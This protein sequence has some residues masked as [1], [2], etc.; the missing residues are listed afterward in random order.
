MWW[1]FKTLS[2]DFNNLELNPINEHNEDYHYTTFY[3]ITFVRIS[4]VTI[5]PGLKVKFWTVKEPKWNPI[6]KYIYRQTYWW[7]ATEVDTKPKWSIRNSDGKTTWQGHDSHVTN[8][9]SDPW[10][11]IYPANGSSEP[12]P[13]QSTMGTA[14]RNRGCTAGCHGNSVA[15]NTGCQRVSVH[16]L[17][18]FLESFFLLFS[19]LQHIQKAHTGKILP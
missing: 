9:T 15:S 1:C 16:Q 2:C 12:E 13:S 3:S 10:G 4:Y 8:V 7:M 11:A 17:F 18:L 6:T 19:P 5:L 14:V